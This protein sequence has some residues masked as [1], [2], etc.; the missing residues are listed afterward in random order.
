MSEVWKSQRGHWGLGCGCPTPA[1]AR[2]VCC[3]CCCNA[4]A[5]AA[6]TA[7]GACAWCGCWSGPDEEEW[8]SEVRPSFP[9]FQL[10]FCLGR[11][12]LG[13]WGWGDWGSWMGTCEKR[14]VKKQR[15]RNDQGTAVLGI[16]AILYLELEGSHISYKGKES[17]WSKK[18]GAPISCRR[19]Y[20]FFK[21]GAEKGS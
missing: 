11:G 7:D 20:T 15:S 21:I 16:L 4:S 5:A 10:F 17:T 19:K 13:S 18:G 6:A 12:V 9:F 8:C 1:A 2:N 14:K 3:C